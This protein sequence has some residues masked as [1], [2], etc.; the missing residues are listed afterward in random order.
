MQIVKESL[1]EGY[2]DIAGRVNDLVFIG[3]QLIDKSHNDLADILFS[4][5]LRV[6]VRCEGLRYQR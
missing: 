2:C 1:E 5:F 6:D 3:P 4:P